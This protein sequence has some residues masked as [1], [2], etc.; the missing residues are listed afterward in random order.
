MVSREELLAPIDTVPDVNAPG[1]VLHSEEV[2]AL[3]SVIVGAVA[4][5]EGALD[6]GAVGDSALVVNEMAEQDVGTSASPTVSGAE[7]EAGR[8]D[9][10][11]AYIK[12]VRYGRVP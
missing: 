4:V 3:L 2:V 6:M 12:L 11:V 1:E 7:L 5:L 10:V 8:V 9:F